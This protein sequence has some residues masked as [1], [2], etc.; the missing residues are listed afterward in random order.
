MPRWRAAAFVLAAVVLSSFFARAD[1]ASLEAGAR[2]FETQRYQEAL[3]K[4]S[5]AVKEE[6]SNARAAELYGRAL[7]EENEL[8]RAVEW[9]ERATTLDPS[10]SSASYWL[11]RAYGEQAIHGNL[12]LRARLAGRI[13]RA[14]E[15]ALELDPDNADARIGLLE[16]YL[17]A[18]S[19]MGGSFE[20]ARAL[21][22]DLRR[23]DPFRAHLA[24]ARLEE[25]RKRRDL[26]DAE[27]E[28][29]IRE[30]PG[31]PEPYLWIERSAVDRKDWSTA[32]ESIERL[33]RARPDD[34]VALYEIGR[35]AAL[36]GR[37]LERGE[38]SL[39]RYL[40]HSPRGDE[41]SR[42]DTHFRLAEIGQR[43]G[44]RD[45]ARREYR[46]ALELDPGAAA[47]RQALAKLR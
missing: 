9:L 24:K 5:S 16:F 35:I 30:F 10:S 6:P 42:A 19:F 31:R 15:R 45:G 17:Q 39:K 44:D 26:A 37:D 22:D 46:T 36:S 21:T 18:P 13:R 12:M 38:A 27:Y 8:P 33:L 11:G 25:H 47:A 32:V 7:Y 14:F 4:L 20:K 34:P 43:R 40:E 29:A 3:E 1:T 2:A 28:A 23:R 41:P